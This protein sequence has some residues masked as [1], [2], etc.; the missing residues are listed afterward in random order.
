MNSFYSYVPQKSRPLL[1]FWIN[2]LNV[3]IKISRP[4]STKLGDF[5]VN[6]NQMME[7]PFLAIRGA[8]AIQGAYDVGLFITKTSEDTQDRRL[9]FQTRAVLEPKPMTVHYQ[10]G[11]ML[12]RGD[13]F[14]RDSGVNIRDKMGLDRFN[15]VNKC[16]GLLFREAAKGQYYNKKQ[17]ALKFAD[18]YRL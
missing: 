11:H 12:D 15:Q 16:L 18:K 8:S 14:D 9:F 4:R 13:A 1:Q 17:F 6:R 5:K 3:K 10:E 2:K 7:N